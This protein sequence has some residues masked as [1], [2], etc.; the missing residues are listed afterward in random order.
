MPSRGIDI[1]SFEIMAMEIQM[2]DALEERL[3]SRWRKVVVGQIQDCEVQR[4]RRKRIDE[5][6]LS[7]T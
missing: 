5:D 1:P 6:F 7:T 4:Q 3:N 2:D